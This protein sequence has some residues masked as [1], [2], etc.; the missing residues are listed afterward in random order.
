MDTSSTV[1]TPQQPKSLGGWLGHIITL[2]LAGTAGGVGYGTV[3]AR[4]ASLEFRM[5]SIENQVIME[6]REVQEDLGDLRVR[7]AEMGNDVR[8][9]KEKSDK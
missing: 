9:L 2:V 7:M 1:P 5:D 8:W 3:E 6:L 4:V